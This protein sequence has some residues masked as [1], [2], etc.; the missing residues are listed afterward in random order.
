MRYVGDLTHDWASGGG[1]AL[2][3]ILILGSKV[4]LDTQ[5]GSSGRKKTKEGRRG[6]EHS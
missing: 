4:T 1:D 2:V 6:F 5:L 3:I